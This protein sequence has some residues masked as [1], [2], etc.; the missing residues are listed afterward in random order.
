[1]PPKKGMCHYSGKPHLQVPPGTRCCGSVPVCSAR[2]GGSCLGG[3]CVLG[4]HG[5]GGSSL[6]TVPRMSHEAL[7]MKRFQGGASRA[8]LEQVETSYPAVEAPK[9]LGP[10]QTHVSPR[11]GQGLAVVAPQHH[12]SGLMFEMVY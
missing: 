10:T 7:E 5:H 9:G 1:M 11:R 3:F 6:G 4:D 8:A 2:A 12:P